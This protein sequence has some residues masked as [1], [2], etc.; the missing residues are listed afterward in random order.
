MLNELIT[1]ASALEVVKKYE[2][3]SDSLGHFLKK[4]V[5]NTGVLPDVAILG[6]PDARGSLC[7]RLPKVLMQSG[8]IYTH[9]QRFHQKLIFSILGI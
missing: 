8:V 4:Q 2:G 5:W 9:C 6:L 3:S 7:P 1:P